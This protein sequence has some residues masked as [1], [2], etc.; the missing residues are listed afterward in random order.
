MALALSA[1]VLASIADV[2]TTRAGIRS[3][4]LVERN[5]LMLWATRST[6]RAITVKA[7]GIAL[8]AALMVP[9]SESAPLTSLVVLWLAALGTGYLAWQNHRTL[10]AIQRDFP[11]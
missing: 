10:R 4:L 11:V 6:W 3:G 2:L 1:L 7:G 5:P 9:N 8:G